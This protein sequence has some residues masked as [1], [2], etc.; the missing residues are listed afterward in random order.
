MK[1]IILQHWSGRLGPL[2]LA[3]QENMEKYA[4]QCDFK[5]SI[6]SGGHQYSGLSSC[7]SNINK[8]IQID[9]SSLNKIE[10]KMDIQNKIEIKLNT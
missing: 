5:V 8:C 10:M 2:E 1:N 6:R 7:N 3:S 9:V 4:K